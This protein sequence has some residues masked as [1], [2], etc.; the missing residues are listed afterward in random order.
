V[1]TERLRDRFATWLDR[2]ATPGR[3][4]VAGWLLFLV[5][6][7]PGYLSPDPVQQLYEARTSNYSDWHPPIMGV[8]WK[9]LEHVITGTF[10]ML[11]LQSTALLFGL[12]RI[13]GTVLSPRRA[14]CAAIAILLFPPVLAPMAVIWKDC[15]MAGYVLAGTALLLST[16]LRWRLVGLALL[17]LGGAMRYNGLGATLPIVVLLFEWRVGLRWW[18]RYAIASAVWLAM[19]FTASTV[20]RKLADYEIRPWYQTA[21]H[22]ISGIIKRGPARDDAELERLLPGVLHVH[23]DIQAQISRAYAP[24]SNYFLTNGEQ[25]I[26]DYPWSEEA[27]ATVR[28]VWKSLLFEYPDLYLRHRFRV[29]KEILSWTQHPVLGPVWDGFPD[30][31]VAKFDAIN[32]TMTHSAWQAAWVHALR[33]FG[34]TI[35]FRAWAYLLVA[36]VLVW[37]RRRSRVELALLASGICY[38]GT[39]LIAAVPDSRYSHWMVTCTVLVYV[40]A[41]IARYREGRR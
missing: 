33:A 40:M 1:S 21:L 27:R 28:Q 19:T 16:R 36:L 11:V 3:I 24:Y 22:D 32:V 20:N 2:V 9:L 26:Y 39:L 30:D 7:Y 25:R 18:Q 12:V 35:L 10:G 15:Q 31:G 13:L 23:H 14:A 17:W 37:L 34:D 8:L 41:M 29:A 38:E 6:A 4:V 5:Y